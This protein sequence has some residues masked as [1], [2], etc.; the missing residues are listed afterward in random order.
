M[1]DSQVKK[2]LFIITQSEFGGAQ[3]FLARLV[4]ILDKNKYDILVAAGQDG[5]DENGLLKFLER[6]GINAKHLGYLRRAVNPLFDLGLG[7]IEIY[8]LIK[9]EK[10]DVL[11]L[12]SSKAGV[13]G[14]LA[15]RLARVSKIIYRIGGWAFNDPRHW[16]ENFFY[17]FI[18]RISA[19]WK[20]VVI[21]NAECLKKQA[22]GFG[23]NPKKEILTIYNGVDVSVLEFLPKE[24]AKKF[25][26]LSGFKYDRSH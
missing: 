24:E 26:K 23:I 25:L 16:W 11:F 6:R 22:V 13:L 19:C 21:V 1:P 7:L 3:Q 9:T 2:I 18:E 12:L 14:S 4:T 20:D 17:K 15:G 10:P 5:D 8:R